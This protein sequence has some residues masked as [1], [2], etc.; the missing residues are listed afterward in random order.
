MEHIAKPIVGIQPE[1]QKTEVQQ[2]D[3]LI[4]P[5]KVKPESPWSD[6]QIR[7]RHVQNNLA[8]GQP[9]HDSELFRIAVDIFGL[10]V[11][12]VGPRNTK[13]LQELME[14]VKEKF[15]DDPTEILKFLQRAARELS[16]TNKHK[17]LLRQL[18]ISGFNSPETPE[19]KWELM[20]EEYKMLKEKIDGIDKKISERKQN[21]KI[22]G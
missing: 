19:G 17:Q 9:I 22:Y 18:Q 16:G 11:D 21:K 7:T 5:E 15:K 12:D 14:L 6:Q 4:Q 20:R 8:E 2:A 13:I 1:P 10:E 3:T